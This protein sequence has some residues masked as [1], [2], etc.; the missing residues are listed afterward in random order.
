MEK[1]FMFD[2]NCF[3]NLKF[4]EIGLLKGN[5]NEYFITPIQ[6]RELE[7]QEVRGW[8][9]LEKKE[10]LLTVFKLIEKR[11][12]ALETGILGHSEAGK[13]PMKL[14][15]TGLFERFKTELDK[16][17][18]N[19]DNN[20]DDALIAEAAVRNDVT[21]VTNEK[22]LR[23]VIENTYPNSVISFEDFKKTLILSEKC[24]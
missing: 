17:A 8:L 7:E 20:L 5:E 4:R 3:Y 24:S 14:G 13:L 10:R 1:K 19:D 22:K 21:L 12:I 11:E 15:T 9:T 2:T 18:K 16:L 6:R 23:E